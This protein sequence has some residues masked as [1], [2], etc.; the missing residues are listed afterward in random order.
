[1]KKNT[2]IKSTSETLRQ[3][4]EELL[5]NKPSKHDS[6]LSESENLRLIYELQV[7]QIELELQNEELR[8]AQAVADAAHGKYIRLY[9]LAP[10][11][12]F[13][14]SPKGEIIELNLAGAL[15]LGKDRSHLINNLFH[16]FI[17]K[18]T[19]DVFKLFLEKSFKNNSKESCEVKLMT[20]GNQSMWVHLSGITAEN[21]TTCLITAVDVTERKHAEKKLQDI[22]EKNPMSI[23]ILDM[24]GYTVH[25]NSAHFNL[26]GAVVPRGYS[27]FQDPQLVQQGFGALFDRIK[28]GEVI[29]FPD[30]YFN[31]HDVN[32]SFPDVPIT[33]KAHG[34]PLTDSHGI[35]EKIVLM[36]ENITDRKQ[37]ENEIKKKSAILNNL[38]INLDAGILLED[39]NRKIVLTNQLFCDMFTIP[40]PPDALAGADCSESAE[41]NKHFFINPENFVAGINLLLANKKAVYN[42]ELELLD[43]R[44]FERDYIPTWLNEVYSGHLWKYRDIT[45]RK[46]AQ[47][48][49]QASEERYHSMFEGS[50]D[51]ILI[52]DAETKMI[53]YANSAICRIFGYTEEQFQTMSIAAI[54]PQDTFAHTLAEFESML[55]GEKNLA[56]NIQCLKRNGE[57]FY[58]DISGALIPFNGRT[59][60][61]GFFRDITYRKQ[62]ETL[63][64]AS[65]EKYRTDLIFLQS[66]LES[67]ISIVI[68]SL[69]KNYCYTK[70]SLSHKETMKKIWGIDI[71]IGMNMVDLIPNM[72]DRN[73]AK[74]NFD[75]ALKG[76]SF[77]V[78]EEYGDKE[79]SRIYYDDYYSPV[80]D[81]EG[82]IVGLS[83]FILDV[84]QRRQAELEVIELNSNLEKTVNYRTTQFKEA[85][86]RLE[87]IADRVPGVVYQFQMNPDGSSCF[88]YASDGI[89]D[90]YRVSP[91]EVIH[92]ASAVF[93]KIHPVDLDGVVSSI[94]AS[95]KNNTIWQHEYRVKFDDGTVRWLS[96]NA[97]PQANEDGTILWHGFITDIT[98]RKQVDEDLDESREKYRGLSEASFE[99]IFFSEN[100]R[101]IE[102]NMAAEIMFGYTNEEALSRYGTDWIAPEY[103]EIVMNNMLSGTED[104][105]EAIAQRKDGTTFPCM[106]RGRMMYYKGRNV[107]VT[108]LTDI[109]GQKM[110]QDA[111]QFQNIL[112]STMISNISDVIGIMGMDG[113]MKYK[114][115]NI[116]K[117]FGWKPQ[118]LIGTDGWSTIYPD[119]LDRIQKEFSDLVKN[120]KSV[121]TVTYRY[122]CKNGSYKPIELTATN[123]ANDPVI[124]GVLLNY[125]DITEREEAENSLRRSEAEKAA[126]IR[127]VPDLMFRIRRDG[128]YLD[129]MSPDQNMLFVP[130]E[131]FIKKTISQVLPPDLALQ[132]MAAIEKAFHLEE[133]TGFEYSLMVKDKLRYF[134]N[135][136]IVS[137]ADEVLSIIRDITFRKESEAALAMQS[138]AFE[139]FALAIII[140]DIKGIIQWA[141]SAFTGLTGYTAVEAIGKTPGALVKSGKQDKDFYKR[142]W[143]TLLNKEVWTGELINRRKDGSLYYEEQTIT[144]VL[145]SK[146]NISSFISIKIDITERKK[147]FQQIADQR[148]RLADIL[149][150][151]NA[152]TWEWNVQTGETIFNEQWAEMLGY[153]L[154]EIS[155]VSIETWMKF[156]HP[157]DLKA[158][159]ELLE[160]YFKGE[161]DY[162][163]FE[164]RMKHKSGEWIWVLDRGRVHEWDKD[165]KPVLMSG[166]HQA[167]TEQKRIEHALIVAKN[168][169]EK[170]NQAKSEFLSRMSH[171]LR[172]P[173]NSILGFTQL[174]EMGGLDPK[175]KKGVNHILNNGRHLLNLINE[176]LDISGIE[177]GRVSLSFVPVHLS[178]IIWE[179]IDTIDPAARAMH[180]KFELID[181]GHEPLFVKADHHRLRQVLINLFN[182]AVKYNRE[183]GSVM[184]KT[185]LQPVIAPAIAF[186]RISVSDTG[187]GINPEFIGKLFM[188]FE[189]IGAEKTG[190]EGTGLGLMVVKKLMD[191][192][193]GSVGVES[194]P[195]EGSTFWIE[196]PYIEVQEITSE[197]TEY[198]SVTPTIIS[199]KT[200]TI[201]YIE[202]NA[203]N[204]E[205]VE[206]ILVNHRPFIQLVS[207]KKGGQ[208]VPMAIEYAP[209]LILLDLDLPD[210]QGFEVIKLLQAEEKT[211]AIPVVVISADAMP[212]QIEKLMIAGAKDYL[213]K[214][215]DIRVFLQVVDE[216]MGSAK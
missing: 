6:Q 5:K 100:G 198:S 32:P 136:I 119:D 76:D 121:K 83:V 89:R 161:L 63:L 212:Q 164:S 132:S 103:R 154:E 29:S 201:L 216:W 162:Y 69:D 167:I 193:G 7:H 44:H 180:V 42:D 94:Q 125:H 207:S 159:G 131:Q 134:E 101:C 74:N 72:E 98:E 47:Q 19:Q 209:D 34:F 56:E 1:M 31:A 130:E 13:T 27:L 91:D 28:N 147:L 109:T 118:D 195:G 203:S 204:T 95:A 58:V 79:L 73:K 97:L 197:Q 41:Q 171:E 211:M 78:E 55:R 23:Q 158:S 206:Q 176:V 51:G 114:S 149:K 160:K 122:K 115:P 202:D 163:T 165:G 152:G 208:A 87:K 75:R 85:L 155:P 45:E 112:H 181:A 188:P 205:L 172:T 18:D 199:E 133:M 142:F 168:E 124:Q 88:P 81:A 183:G 62:A 26:F 135:R 174:M 66:I 52:A 4:A 48:E 15:M 20:S 127:A 157:D 141:N 46:H 156:A 153:T 137:S 49:L 90:I 116:E 177:A 175:H 128:T 184:I 120:D 77:V 96:G 93:T 169:A 139:S 59:Q 17:S 144:P 196:L 173:M 60:L 107:R 65:E 2:E 57:I 170:A 113:V 3:K 178:R 36:Q 213:T 14:L 185:K 102:Q 143:D 182:N 22:I 146:G 61:L 37:A 187:P 126:I 117:Y 35:P 38:I 99:A 191:A 39:S 166:T 108:S 43:G 68:F 33:I 16:F 192:M 186:V 40:A 67:P 123:L 200:R 210:V 70:F 71:R 86:T 145:D 53:N 24:E 50:P 8:N 21:G 148:R 12:Y 215:L 140:T 82:N 190:I 11:G 111:L 189:R 54:H 92:D 194:V 64:K 25:T 150:G 214:P 106:I 30:S 10:S 110:A 138:A 104:P 151:T 9:D 179:A 129:Y 105:Y 84:S 80:K